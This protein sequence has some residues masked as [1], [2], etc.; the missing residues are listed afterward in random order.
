MEALIQKTGATPNACA[1][2]T[3][4]SMC[5]IAPCLGTPADILKIMKAGHASKI[6]AT[7]WMTGQVMSNLPPINMFQ[8]ETSY[9]NGCVFLSND[10][11]TL[12][13]LDLKPS[14]GRLAMCRLPEGQSIKYPAAFAVALT[15]LDPA[16]ERIINEIMYRYLL[17]NG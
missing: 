17:E 1:C 7:L 3:C 5:K 16:N 10:L 9:A 4:A 14:E 15:W 11:C 6:K 2:K 13:D 12:H 8:A